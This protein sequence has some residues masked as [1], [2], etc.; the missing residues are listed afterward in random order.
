MHKI[1]FVCTGNICRSPSAEAV[2][3]HQANQQGAKLEISSSGTHGYHIGEPSDPRAIKHA[4][5]RG[6][7]MSG[8]TAQKITTQD[9]Q[10][11]DLIIAMDQGHMRILEDIRPEACRADLKLFTDF[12]PEASNQD[13]PDP[14]YGDFIGFELVLD[15]L[16]EGCSFILKELA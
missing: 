1:M 15:M 14:Y 11:Y 13:V 2:L 12:M 7:D 6:I 9:F 4:A 10:D 8:I 3:R 16:E 5:K